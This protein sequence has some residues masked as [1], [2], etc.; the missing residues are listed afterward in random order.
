MAEYKDIRTADDITDDHVQEAA[1]ARQGAYGD[2]PA[3]W[4]EVIDRLEKWSGEDWGTDMHSE[5]IR[6]LKRRVNKE[7][8]IRTQPARDT[9]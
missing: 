1:D 7:L 2:R 6:A 3:T 8:G 4:E 5:A 9:Q